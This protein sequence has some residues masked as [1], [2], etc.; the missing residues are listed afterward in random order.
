MD[1]LSL[2]VA[3]LLTKVATTVGAGAGDAA[4]AAL[5]RLS[6]AVR[7]RLARRRDGTQVLD[8]AEAQPD[9]DAGTQ[10]LAAALDTEIGADPGFAEVLRA[11]VEEARAADPSI[12]KFITRVEA[13]AQVG[14]I[15]NI[16]TV[17]GDV[18]I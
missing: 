8:A 12:A 10:Q 13:G 3:A 5:K 14:K 17:Q 15:V 18:N 7:V 9:D 1:P 4:V 16:D 11:L 2:T 6:H